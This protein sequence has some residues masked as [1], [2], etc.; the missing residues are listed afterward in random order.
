MCF[1]NK[2]QTKFACG[3]REAVEDMEPC[4]DF[5][6]YGEC[7]NPETNYFGSNTARNRIFS[8]CQAKNTTK[9]DKKDKQNDNKGKDDAEGRQSSTT[10]YSTLFALC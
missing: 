4:Q 7:N 5:I 8:K 6:T 10:E 9:N 1:I 2:D 3:H